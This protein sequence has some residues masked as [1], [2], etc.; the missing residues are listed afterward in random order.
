[1]HPLHYFSFRYLRI[2]NNLPEHV[3]STNVTKAFTN[4]VKQMDL[5]T[6]AN[7]RH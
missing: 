7:I 4:Y 2:W 6:V 5:H 1:M 3:V